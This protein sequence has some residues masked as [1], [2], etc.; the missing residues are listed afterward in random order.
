MF[1]NSVGDKGC[2]MN[3]SM[4]NSILNCGGNSYKMIE[5]KK[6]IWIPTVNLIFSRFM[7]FPM[8]LLL[9]DSSFCCCYAAFY[10]VLSLSTSLS[11]CLSLFLS[12]LISLYLFL[13]LCLTYSLSLS[14]YCICIWTFLFL[15]L[16]QYMP[17]Q[18]TLRRR[19]SKDPFHKSLIL[20]IPH[21]RQ[22]TL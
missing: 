4:S 17:R 12:L 6:V 1:C 13:S 20:A 15:F 7:K 10:S 9:R 18:R 16:S 11:V 19:L 3:G 21:S 8:K 5:I 14:M 2:K 22:P